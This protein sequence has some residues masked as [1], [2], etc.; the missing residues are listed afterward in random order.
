MN[1]SRDPLDPAMIIT[2][3]LSKTDA[4]GNVVLPKAEVKSVLTRMKKNVL[5]NGVLV[6]KN[7]TAEDLQS[8]VQVKVHDLMKYKLYTVTLKVTEIDNPR[9]YFGSGWS[10][11]KHS[12]DLG[13]GRFLKLYWDQFEQEFIVLNFQYNVLQIMIRV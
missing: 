5:H 7:I 9:Y 2:K 12:L 3:K 1:Y 4:V 11:M 6:E 13:E 10:D 8:G